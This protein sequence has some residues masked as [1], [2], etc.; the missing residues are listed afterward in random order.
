SRPVRAL[1]RD[2]V[3]SS[4]VVTH[5]DPS[6]TATALGW[7]PTANVATRFVPGSTLASRS[8]DGGGAAPIGDW[9]RLAKR[10]APSVTNRAVSDAMRIATPLS[11]RLPKPARARSRIFCPALLLR[12]GL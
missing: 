9:P 10:N 7:T 4:T 3:L 2:N 8:A 5:T 1:I 12:R 6:P 11:R